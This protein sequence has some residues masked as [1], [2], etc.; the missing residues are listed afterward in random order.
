[1]PFDDLP[2]LW[3]SWSPMFPL[4]SSPWPIRATDP[5]GYPCTFP[6]F[7]CGLYDTA[8]G[9]G[10]NCL[11]PTIILLHQCGGWGPTPHSR[12][13]G[14]APLWNSSH[15]YCSLRKGSAFLDH[16]SSRDCLGTLPVTYFCHLFGW[17]RLWYMP[18]F[19]LPFPINLTTGNLPQPSALP[20]QMTVP[21]LFRHPPLLISPLTQYLCLM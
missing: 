3:A 7:M 1:M 21:Y 12:T 18:H 8:E 13:A 5:V 15:I 4:W 16:P 14:H 17:A 6:L 19:L 9:S 11:V 2:P 10:P 20:V